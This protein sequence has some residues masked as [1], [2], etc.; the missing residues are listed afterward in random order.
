MFNA[1]SLQLW[2]KYVF[3]VTGT[4]PTVIEFCCVLS[5][6]N[7]TCIACFQARYLNV[8]S[9]PTNEAQY[10]IQALLLKLNPK[11]WEI[12]QDVGHSVWILHI[13]SG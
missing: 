12:F 4:E 5:F 6:T 2:N 7:C 8:P 10:D 1:I 9:Q 11:Y 13:R 3:R